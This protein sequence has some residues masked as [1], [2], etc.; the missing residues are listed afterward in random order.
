MKKYF[1]DR[2]PVKLCVDELHEKRKKK[3]IE[4]SAVH[5][6]LNIISGE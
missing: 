2:N 6:A 5:S 1:I 4:T 3:P